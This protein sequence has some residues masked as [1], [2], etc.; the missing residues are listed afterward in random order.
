MKSKKGIETVMLAIVVIV[1]GILALL[2]IIVFFTGAGG[3]AS[4]SFF[5]LFKTTELSCEE[6]CKFER[7][8]TGTCQLNATA[9]SGKTVG[10]AD[11]EAG[12]V[13]CCPAPT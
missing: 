4:E 2:F 10:V 5:N 11:C 3:K 8:D 12:Q 9:C 7:F 6:K 13:C 1:V